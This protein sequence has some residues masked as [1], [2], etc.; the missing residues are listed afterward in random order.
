MLLGKKVHM[1]LQ[2]FKNSSIKPLS[3]GTLIGS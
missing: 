1:Y 3:G 2:M